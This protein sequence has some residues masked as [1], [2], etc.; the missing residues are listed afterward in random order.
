MVPVF[1]RKAVFGETTA[2]RSFN[3]P[4]RV[5]NAHFLRPTAFLVCKL[6]KDRVGNV[7]YSFGHPSHIVKRCISMNSIIDIKQGRNK[8]ERK[9]DTNAIMLV[10][11]KNPLLQSYIYS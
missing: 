9:I 6:Y 7:F 5:E 1:L 8:N 2:V 3:L 4:E 10:I 11:L